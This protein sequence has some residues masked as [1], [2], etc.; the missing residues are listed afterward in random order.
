M[1]PENMLPPMRRASR[2]CPLPRATQCSSRYTQNTTSSRNTIATS[3]KLVGPNFTEKPM[4][5]KGPSRPPA[6]PPA[7]MKPNNRLP[8]SL[9]KTSAINDQNTA[10]AKKLKTLTQT[11]KA[12]ATTVVDT[13]SVSSSQKSARFV[14]KNW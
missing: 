3:S 8:C 1:N 13:F 10:T 14:T 4:V 11:K 6:V 7:P 12:R 2:C 5:I 9:V